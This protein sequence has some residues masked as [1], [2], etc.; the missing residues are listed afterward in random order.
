[1]AR[2]NNYDKKV[3]PYLS[4]IEQMALTMTEEQIAETLGVSYS[5]FRR[6]KGEYKQLQTALKVGRRDLVLELRST[7]IKKARGFDY[8]ETKSIKVRNI[9][10]GEMEEIKREE[11]TKHAPPDVAAM[12]LLLKNYDKENWANDPQALEIRKQEIELQKQKMEENS[13]N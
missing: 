8:N 12:N 13:W 1:M 2:P 3:K 9:E 7:L 10:T 6:Y 5:T 4:K 11:Y